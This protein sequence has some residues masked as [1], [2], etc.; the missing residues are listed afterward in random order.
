MKRPLLLISIALLFSTAC[1]FVALAFDSDWLAAIVSGDETEY[2]I[3][4]TTESFSDV[5]V[6]MPEEQVKELL[7]EPLSILPFTVP[8]EP[9]A[10]AALGADSGRILYY[11][12]PASAKSS[13]YVVSIRVD[14][15]NKVISKQRVFYV[16]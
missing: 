7:G 4:F 9:S 14:S 16:D 8:S 13:W 15:R 2:A 1:L 11:S 6:G 10:E 12:K 5:E 3:G